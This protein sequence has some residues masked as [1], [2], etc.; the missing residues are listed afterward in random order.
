[1]SPIRAKL[2]DFVFFFIM[3]FKSSNKNGRKMKHFSTFSQRP[4]PQAPW[5][6]SPEQ[7]HVLAVPTVVLTALYDQMAPQL[8]PFEISNFDIFST[9]PPKHVWA[10][11]DSPG[12]GKEIFFF[13]FTISFFRGFDH[14]PFSFPPP[15]DLN[16]LESSDRTKGWPPCFR[17]CRPPQSFL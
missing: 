10:L 8:C 16:V 7:D 11:W 15:G 14:R 3:F 17:V 9:T 5:D 1:M 4:S 2:T 13:P 12:G 6:P